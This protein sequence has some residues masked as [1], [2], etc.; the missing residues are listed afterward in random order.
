MKVV[1]TLLVTSLLF[2]GFYSYGIKKFGDLSRFFD[3][4][5]YAANIPRFDREKMT[6]LFLAVFSQIIILIVLIFI[7]GCN[8]F[9]GFKVDNFHYS[10]ILDG[11]LLG[12]GEMAVAGLL[13]K[14]VMQ[15]V[16]LYDKRNSANNEITWINEGKGGWVL[17]YRKLIKLTP[18]FVSVP[19]ILLYVGTEELIFRYIVIE[20]SLVY[21]AIFAILFSAIWFTIVQ[22]YWMPSHRAALFPAIGAALMGIVH[23]IIFVNDPNIVPLIIAHLVFFLFS[24]LPEILTKKS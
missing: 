10:V 2:H 9:S 16:F 21:G 12:I 11:V 24:V 7:T 6:R 17:E 15:L 8:P 1:L 14:V 20:Y 13:A 4:F 5:K 3:V 18:V 23:G 19:I 22:T